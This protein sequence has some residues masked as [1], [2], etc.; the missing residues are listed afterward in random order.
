[1]ENC[2][3]IFNFQLYKKITINTMIKEWIDNKTD[4][5]EINYIF[6]DSFMYSSF[7]T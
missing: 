2:I 3:I 7:F 1:M 5:S 6:Y 4:I